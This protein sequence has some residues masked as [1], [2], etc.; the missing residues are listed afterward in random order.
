[1]KKK[2]ANAKLKLKKQSIRI[3]S[4]PELD[5]IL[6]GGGYCSREVADTGC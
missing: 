4:E 1:V 3:L 5:T 6:G 2:T